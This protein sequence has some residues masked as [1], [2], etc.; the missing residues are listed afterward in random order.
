MRVINGLFI[1]NQFDAVHHAEVEIFRNETCPKSLNFV[2]SRF[3]RKS[4]LLLG[5]DRAGGR[6][7]TDRKN[8]FA[9]GI[10]DVAR[11]S[12]DGATSTDARNQNVNGAVGIVPNFRAGGFLVD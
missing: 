3:E 4:L 2:W 6:F 7:N 1:R 12:S 8:F 10:F 5:D 11:N 9:L